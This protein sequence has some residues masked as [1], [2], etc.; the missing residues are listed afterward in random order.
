MK[1]WTVS[2]LD[3]VVASLK[4]LIGARLQEVQTTKDDVVLGFY[5][6]QGLLW[7]WIDLAATRPCL[8]P[9]SELPLHLPSR[10]SPLNL[11][12]RAHFSDR[13]LRLIERP[14]ELGRV[15]RLHF[16]KFEDELQIEIRLMNHSRNILARTKDKKIAWQKP[17]DLQEYIPAQDA[18]LSVKQRS[19]DE[20]R[21]EWSS[22]RGA[23][24]PGKTGK[25]VRQRLENE[26]AK[27]KKAV[28]KMRDELE[29]KKSLPW[30]VV[31][32]WLKENQSLEVPKDWELFV[33]K[34]RKLSW[35]IE[36]CFSKA[37][38]LEGKIYGAEQRLSFLLEEIANLE[39]RRNQPLTTKSLEKLPPQPLAAAAAQG[40]TLRI[41]E[42][43]TVVAGKSAADNLKLL[44]KARS[45]DLW[46]HLKDEPASHAILFRN[47]GTSISEAVIQQVSEWYVRQW[48]G[49]KYK[50]HSGEKF[51]I[52]M[53]ECRYVRPIVNPRS[54]RHL[55]VHH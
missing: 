38:E 42:E 22:F 7:L 20:L 1:A 21:S 31:G 53:A 52:L 3:N 10:K 44:R 51:L 30:K 49:G 26:L 11:F 37:R 40:R 35:N 41:N 39:E 54:R 27:K 48:L 15:I 29:R 47:K 25:D 50:A 2:E 32:S 17:K 23:K 45:W 43:I 24:G 5:T 4:P 36:E 16:G 55:A 46:F 13:V 12:I 34:R 18:S 19:L 33:D 8:L 6:P 14:P 9:W 28:D